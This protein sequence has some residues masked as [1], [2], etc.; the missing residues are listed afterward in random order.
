MENKMAEDETIIEINESDYIKWYN[1]ARDTIKNEELIPKRTDAEIIDLVSKEGWILFCLEGDTKEITK[2]K[3]EPNIFFDLHNREGNFKDNSRLGLAFNNLKSYERFKMIIKESNKEIKDKITE[4][5]L[6][7][8]ND[9]KINVKR[10][11]KDYNYGQPPKYKLEKEWCSNQINESI[12]AEIIGIANLIREQ[13]INEGQ[14]REPKYYFEGPAINFMESEFPLQEEIFKGKILEAFNILSLCLKIPTR[15]E[16]NQ[17]VRRMVKRIAELEILKEHKK[18]HIAK[19][20][21]L[22][23]VPFF[24]KED[25]EKQEKE[26][27]ELEKELEDLK[28]KV[29][30]NKV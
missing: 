26:L 6:K 27:E 22:K 9:W 29:E 4:K 12:V 23:D 10:K 24:S 25:V 20:K 7:L 19:L 16:T 3:D 2:N 17:E 11:I 28:K 1:L 21:S 14:K 18:E 13:G 30:E 15:V 8:N 5:L